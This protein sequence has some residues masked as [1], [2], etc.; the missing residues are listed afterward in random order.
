MRTHMNG[1]KLC[2]L[3]S[4]GAA[5]M[6]VSGMVQLVEG[7][8]WTGNV[9][10]IHKV[11]N[12]WQV[13]SVIPDL[14]SYRIKDDKGNPVCIERPFMVGTREGVIDDA[15]IKFSMYSFESPQTIIWNQKSFQVKDF[16]FAFHG[17]EKLYSNISELVISPDLATK[18]EWTI[19]NAD[20]KNLAIMKVKMLSK[21]NCTA[22]YEEGVSITYRDF[23]K[24]F[25]MK[26]D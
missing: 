4:L 26:T 24:R 13:T 22:V 7:V 1:L 3:F 6:L 11:G 8:Q 5:A 17:D 19:T 16:V 15:A 9:P 18:M 21:D 14:Y 23:K 2:L 10:S 20:G 25:L 12:A